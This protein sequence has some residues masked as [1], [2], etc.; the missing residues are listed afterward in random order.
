MRQILKGI[1]SRTDKD[2][3]NLVAIS[4]EIMFMGTVIQMSTY[5]IS[6]YGHVVLVLFIYLNLFITRFVITGFWI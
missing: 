2:F 6:I 4:P 5:N 1:Y 3:R